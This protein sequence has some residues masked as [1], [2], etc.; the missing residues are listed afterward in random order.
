MENRHD[1]FVLGPALP[2]LLRLLR[3]LGNRRPRA[4]FGQGMR[5]LDD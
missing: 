5:R 4:V 3:D 2:Q 1:F